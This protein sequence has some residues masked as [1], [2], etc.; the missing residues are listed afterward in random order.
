MMRLLINLC[1][2][3]RIEQSWECHFFI[4]LFSNL[5]NTQVPVIGQTVMEA[6]TRSCSW[7]HTSRKPKEP[8]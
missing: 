8:N 2:E 6:H 7:K 4:N 5:E 3:G 1:L